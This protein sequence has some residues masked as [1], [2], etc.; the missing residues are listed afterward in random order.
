MVVQEC[1]DLLIKIQGH[2]FKINAYILPHMDT[3][4]DMILGQKPMYELEA[5]PDFGTLTFYIYE[6]IFGIGYYK[7]NCDTT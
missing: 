7:G 3:S 1:I 5:G 4:Y 6:K 2:V